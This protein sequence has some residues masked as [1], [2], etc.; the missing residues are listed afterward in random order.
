MTSEQSQQIANLWMYHSYLAKILRI[1]DVMGQFH[2]GKAREIW[3]LTLNSNWISRPRIAPWWHNKT[4]VAPLS[5]KC[6]KLTRPRHSS[7]WRIR[8]LGA[9]L[10]E[11][12]FRGPS[13]GWRWGHH[14]L[15]RGHHHAVSRRIHGDRGKPR[16]VIWD[17][18]GLV[19]EQLRRGR[20]Q[21]LVHDFFLQQHP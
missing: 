1:D 7:T 5:K 9:V 14:G 20:G 17:A 12:V 4:K 2:G 8:V 6:F 18:V 15:V 19:G 13:R 11:E 3:K 16:E 21:N 10:A